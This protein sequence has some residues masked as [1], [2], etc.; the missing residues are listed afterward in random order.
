MIA[1]RSPATNLMVALL[2]LSSAARLHGQGIADS[3]CNTHVQRTKLG[4]ELLDRHLAE[5]LWSGLP[6]CRVAEWCEG[7][8]QRPVQHQELFTTELK[9]LQTGSACVSV[10][11][12]FPLKKQELPVLRVNGGVMFT[13]GMT[14]DADG[15]PNAYGP[16]NR[17][18]DFTANARGRGGWV[19][20]VTNPKGRP[21]L[22]RTGPYRGYYVSTT[23]LQQQDIKDPRNPKK[24]LDATRIPYIALPPDFAREF[25][26]SLGDLAVVVNVEN[27]RTAYA[28]F[29]DVGPRG[30]IGEGSIA[31]ANKLGIPS[32]P[33]HDS[34]LNGVTYL[35]FP[36]S[37]SSKWKS[38]TLGRI[39]SSAARLHG[40]WSAQKNCAFAAA[41]R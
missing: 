5:C 29:A 19:A 32:N 35:V 14:I 25:G 8:I 11:E 20:L 9:R 16:K 21:V 24:Y 28:I 38:I 37:G 31:L 13:A 39:N 30:K 27:G 3:I 12:L 10:P 18:L 36:G 2:V 4:Q 15:A 33:R 1:M 23:S 22:Q 17:G 7:S 40:E 41:T 34:V 6:S 26:I